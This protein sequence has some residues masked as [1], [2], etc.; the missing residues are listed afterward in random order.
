MNENYFILNNETLQQFQRT[1]TAVKDF[2]TSAF[3]KNA[4]NLHNRWSK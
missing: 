3:H 4:D 1:E 2:C